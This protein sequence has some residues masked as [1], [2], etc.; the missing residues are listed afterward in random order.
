LGERDQPFADLNSD[1][2]RRH[3][4]GHFVVGTAVSTFVGKGW[5]ATLVA[6]CQPAAPGAGILRVRVG[7]FP[8]LQNTNGSVRLA[9]N[10]F[11][12]NGP[13]GAFYPVLVNR[14]AADQFF[15]L[16]TRCQHLGCV[17]PT[18]NASIGA[19]LCPCHCSRYAIDGSVVAGPTTKPLISY[20]NSFDGTI[21]CIEIPGLGYS[22]TGT[23]VQGTV[24]PRFQL[25][26]P[27][28]SGVKY[29]VVLWQS[30]TDPGTTVLFATT[31]GGAA[32]SS[33]LTGN[34]S[35]GTAFVDR[36]TDAGF[37]SIVVQVTQA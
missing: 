2:S 9:L 30:F 31:S 1:L 11:T 24:G 8:A 32:T 6:D 15:A 37:Y 36:A 7:D 14:G 3:F 17:V 21:L 4:I 13:S 16:S 33:V 18:F 10:P 27:T 20:A 19:S 5:L 26:F 34:G 25:Q 22:V 29:R 12:T 28:K 23:A 35:T